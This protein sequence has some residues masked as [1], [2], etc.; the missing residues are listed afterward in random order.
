MQ[1][2]SFIIPTLNE[3]TFLNE[4]KAFFSLLID[5]GHEI[6][7]VDGGSKDNSLNIA[8]ILGCKTISTK[9]SRGFQQHIGAE[10]SINEILVFLHAD[11][12]LPSSA[13]NSIKQALSMPNMKWGRFNVAFTN[14]KFIF[15]IIAWF[16]N[17]RSC[18]TGIVS[19]D[20]T[21]FVKRE[22]YFDCG[23]FSDIPIM[24]D[25]DISKKLK[26]CS[27]PVCLTDKVI[28]SS[29]KWEKNGVLNTIFLMWCL[30]FLFYIGIPAEKLA[31]YYY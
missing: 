16:M 6:I 5:E 30:R 31:K 12:S 17:K 13:L 1:K 27:K 10:I 20:H 24:E 7:I 19:G 25:I 26:K 14:R 11:T 28:T 29:R 8:K 4:Q 22:I 18:L 15:K 9:P 3:E 23:G 21:L 2:I